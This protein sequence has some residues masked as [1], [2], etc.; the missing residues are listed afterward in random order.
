MSNSRLYDDFY[1]CQKP[2]VIFG[3]DIQSKPSMIPIIPSFIKKGM[4]VQFVFIGMHRQPFLVEVNGDQ[5]IANLAPSIKFIANQWYHG[6]VVRE[7]MNSSFVD[8]LMG[9]E[10]YRLKAQDTLRIQMMHEPPSNDIEDCYRGLP[11]P[12]A[13]H[14]REFPHGCAAIE[15]PLSSAEAEKEVLRR[16]LKGQ[17]NRY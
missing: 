13:S 14:Q 15:K 9:E 16:Y 17:G 7:G 10:I 3:S 12:L 8:L 1:Y 2:E 4:L 11:P 6:L 5:Q